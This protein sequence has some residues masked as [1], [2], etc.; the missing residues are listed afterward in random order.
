M[1]RILDTTPAFEAYART[2][3]LDPPALRDSQ[4]GERYEGAH[5]EVFAAFYADHPDKSGRAALVRELSRVRQLARESAPVVAGI[6]ESVE[7]AV[8]AAM[9]LTLPP[10]PQ[11]VLMIGPHTTNA[12]VGRLDGEVALFHCL[13]WFFS[14]EGARILVAHEDTHALHELALGRRFAEDDPAWMAFA[15]GLAVAVSRQAAPDRPD[16]DYFWYGYGG[17]EEWLPWCQEHRADLLARFAAD[18]D[19]PA[20]A[21]TWFGG[22]LVDGRWRVGQFVADELVTTLGRPLP[23]LVAMSVADAQAAIRQTA[24]EH[25]KV[26]S[27]PK[28]E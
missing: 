6:I 8:A 4:W 2:A 7:P 22:G 20:A 28:A 3:F 5:P 17:F 19:D 13:E 21:E 11:H 25:A 14:E 18:L 27:D 9:G 23:E 10:E 12:V 16:N 1:A 15:E 24:G 26:L